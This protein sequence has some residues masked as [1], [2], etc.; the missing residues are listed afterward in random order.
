MTIPSLPPGSLAPLRAPWGWLRRLVLAVGLLSLATDRLSAGEA[1]VGN[2]AVV[3]IAID[4]Q[5]LPPRTVAAGPTLPPVVPWV[6]TDLLVAHL[7]PADWRQIDAFARE[8]Y[9]V[10]AVN[11]LSQWDR[12]GPGAGDYDPAVVQ[13]ADAYLRRF[14]DRVHEAGAKAV[15]YFGPVQPPLQSEVFRARHPDWLRVNEDGSKA[16][17]Y[18]NFRHPDFVRWLTDQLAWLAREYQADGFWFDGYSPVSLH[19]YDADT[20]A[21]FR[22]HSG[23]HDLPSRGKFDPRDP[24]V[25]TYLR[26]HEEYF[27]GLAARLREAVRAAHPGTVIYGNYSASRTWYLPDWPLGEYPAGYAT[28]I[29]LPSVEL[30]W[31]HPGDALFQ[32]FTYAFTQGV[33]ADRGARVWVQPQA[34]GIS[35]TPPDVEILLR[36]LEGAPWGVHAEFVEP[37]GREQH[38]RDYAREVK[39]R[40]AWWRESEPVPFIGL[41]ASEQTRTY[42]GRDTALRYLPHL[43]GAFRALFEAHLPVRVLTEYDLEAADLRGVRVLVLPET[44]VLSDRAGEVV[45][46]FVAAGGGLLATGSPGLYDEAFQARTNFVIADLLHAEFAGEH[47]VWTR[48]AQL[49]LSL[50]TAHPIVSDPAVREQEETAWRDPNGAPPPH[51]PIDLVAGATRVQP[52]DGATVLVQWRTNDGGNVA[53]PALQIAAHG[54]GRVVYAPAGLDQAMYLYPNRAARAL[55]VNS[56]RWLAGDV[57]APVEVDAPLLLAVTCRRQPAAGRTI[58]HLLNDQSSYGRHSLYQKLRLPD[59]SVSGPWSVREEVIPIHDVRVRCRVPGVTKATQQPEG[60]A[61]PLQPLPDGSGCEVRVPQ[62]AMYSL[63]VFE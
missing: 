50:A 54:R 20:R 48:E 13:A 10:I 45:R 24:V 5:A 63:V 60:I 57:P 30:Y 15:F 53:F 62:V 36:G 9:Q 59:G 26:W 32:Q 7:P 22:K 41:V 44:R 27:V 40:A 12:V 42:F 47:E 33:T 56:V 55:L 34:H 61:L 4:G 49:S 39:A 31:D 58:V 52:R 14:V 1:P 43:L 6:R 23:G 11:T 8:G 2:A 28:A 29:D 38:M 51:G 3:P 17:D 37:T 25:R 46:R 21:A 18:V 19:T 16:K 35:G